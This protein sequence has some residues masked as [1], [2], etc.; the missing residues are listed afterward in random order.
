MRMRLAAVL[1]LFASL[2]ARG[3]EIIAHRGASYDAPENTLPAIK[4]GFERGADA[5]EIDVFITEDGKIVAIHDSDTKRVSGAR[6]RVKRS[7]LAEL[8][9]LDVGRWK[10]AE[11]AGTR[12][13]TLE[14]ALAE[15]PAGKRLVVEIKTGMEILGELERIIEASGK[16]SQVTLIAFSF[17]VIRE[18][19]KRMPDVP[20]YWLYGFSAR[21]KALWGVL[22]LD[23][24]IERAGGAGLD[25][26]D[27]KA[28]G[29]FGK[30]F[31]DKLGDAGLELLVYTVNEPRLARRLV[32][33]GVKGITT[34]RPGWLREQLGDLAD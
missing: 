27:L 20:A 28:N 16:R 14:E 21:E 3:L 11:W 8:R 9:E 34:D 26:L 33:L 32:E 29:P 7:T 18:A 31:V 12:I 6:K 1:L 15:V 2:E 25:G 19:K 24:L 30:D 22:G 4:L 10:G 23:T 13:P 17:P 5:V